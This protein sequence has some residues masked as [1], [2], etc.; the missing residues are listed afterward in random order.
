MMSPEEVQAIF[1]NLA[2][3]LKANKAFLQ[4]RDAPPVHACCRFF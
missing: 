3:I 4:V 1:S 2:A